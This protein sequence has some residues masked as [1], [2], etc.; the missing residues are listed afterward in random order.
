MTVNSEIDSQPISF[1]RHRIRTLDLARGLAILFMIM[2]HVV[3]MYGNLDAQLHFI[4]LIMVGLGTLPAAPVFLF[5]MGV[6]FRYSER[7]DSE[8]FSY[9]VRRGIVLFLLGFILNFGR[10]TLPI[11]VGLEEI[12]LDV[13]SSDKG[14]HLNSLSSLFV[15]DILQC[16]GLSLI[17]MAFLVKYIKGERNML[18]CIGGLLIFFPISWNIALGINLNYL[19][20]NLLWGM[21]I[22][23][24][25]PLFPWVIYPIVG[26][27]LGQRLRSGNDFDQLILYSRNLS[28]VLFLITILV[29]FRNVLKDLLIID[30]LIKILNSLLM[31]YNS[32]SL[33]LTFTM[34]TI[35]F[36][37][38]WIWIC[39]MVITKTPHN[40]VYNLLFY[41]SRNVTVMYVIQWTLI[42]WGMLIFGN[43]I[44]DLIMV[45]ILTL[46]I[47][48]LSHLITYLF[49]ILKGSKILKVVQNS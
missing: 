13:F 17:L 1:Q 31:S 30:F 40:H 27:I 22:E 7:N 8:L 39:H 41:W 18:L 11:L 6:C 29:S 32:D 34:L 4:G 44:Q 47:L 43:Q 24:F 38:F 15:I 23:V 36:I 20:L 21:S 10:F 33:S 9:G 49:F 2:Q 35:S 12:S 14:I 25:F 42:G 45:L 37:L 46:S 5:L 48:T 19:I 3:L 16:A 28:I 26:M